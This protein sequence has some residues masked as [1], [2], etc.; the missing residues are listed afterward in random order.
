MSLF[1]KICGMCSREDFEGV[2]AL[3]PD[4]VGF[5][6]WEKSKRYVEPSTV[7]GW[8]RSFD[9]P[10]LKVGVFVDPDPEQALRVAG[11]ARLDVIQAHFFQ[12]LEK[13]TD[14]FPMIGKK[15]RTWMVL[16]L[17]RDP[18]PPVDADRVDA[19]LLDSYSQQSPGGT[20]MTNDWNAARAFV[21]RHEKPVL[22]AGGLNPGNVADA[23]R[24]VRPWGVDVSSGVEERPGKKDISLVKAFIEQCRNT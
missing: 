17:G 16:C 4:A 5:V 3:Q 22:L 7:A 15:Y 20:G 19:Y 8:T 23:V 9:R 2:T 10:V 24:Q 11:E 12:S 18:A 21:E 13:R 14:F 1:V 6:F